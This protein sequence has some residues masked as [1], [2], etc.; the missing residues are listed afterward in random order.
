MNHPDGARRQ[1]S[2][3]TATK[4]RN[5]GQALVEFAII[6]PLFLIVL[7]SVLYFGFLLYSKMSIINAAREGAHY[8]ILL[9]P[10]DPAFDTQVSDQVQGAAGAG[11]NPTS[12]STATQGF[13]V[14]PTTHLVTSTSCTWGN[15]GS[16]V[17]GDAVTVTV[18]YPFANPIPLH[19]V[20]LGNT[21]IDLPTSINISATVQMIHE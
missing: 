18:T 13:H 14:D 11:L 4:N 19:L 2:R 17:A 15:G 16:C 12:V 3:R 21:I 5:R 9:D 20:L 10:S 1:A 7:G 6:F 8:G